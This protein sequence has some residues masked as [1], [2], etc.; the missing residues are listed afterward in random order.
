MKHSIVKFYLRLYAF[1]ADN[2]SY[3]DL[4]DKYLHAHLVTMLSTGVLMWSYAFLA[5]FTISSPV[6]GI[7]GIICS[8]VHLL[9]PLLYRKT[10]RY[11]LNTSVLLA[12]GL[13]H[14]M[15]F[16]YFTGGFDSNILIWLGI[17]PMLGG[18]I[19][20]RKGTILWAFITAAGVLSF[21]VMKLS[22]Y[23]FP[24]MISD[25]GMLIAQA[26]ILFGWIFI[27]TCVIWVHVYLVEQNTSKL[28]ISRMR[29]QNL[30]NIL[31]HDIS[32]PLTVISGKLNSLLKTSL[33]E[34]QLNSVAK[35]CKASERLNMITESIRDLRL[36]EM[37][38]KEIKF[39][40]VDVRELIIELKEIFSEKLEQKNLKLNWSVAAEVYDFHSNRSLLLNQILGNLLSN[41]IKF[42]SHD[43]EIRLRVSRK[44]DSIK[45]LIEDSGLGIPLDMRDNV[46]EASLSRSGIGTEGEIGSGF[47]LP[48][49]KGCV[50]RLGG[51][52]LFETCTSNEGPSFTRFQ[53]FFPI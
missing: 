24:F 52:I 26:L 47:G 46:F 27:A 48:I 49:V 44:D 38:K 30:V 20:G 36:N 40:T 51:K 29:T 53:L 14:Q 21:L 9:S 1:I 2:R 45:F 50:D 3:Q 10:N 41:S 17:L 8:C 39:A 32:T 42:S 23:H 18:V 22:G 13:I 43:S 25:I 31:S 15:T 35:A 7:V 33:N 37:G 19:A 28:E 4:P 11:L 16:A 5:V 12:S 34:T 6:P